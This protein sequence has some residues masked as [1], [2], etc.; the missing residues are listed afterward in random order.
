MADSKQNGETPKNKATAIT[1][2]QDA[3]SPLCSNGCPCLPKDWKLSPCALIWLV[4][5]AITMVMFLA[6]FIAPNWRDDDDVIIGLRKICAFDNCYNFVGDSRILK[7]G[8]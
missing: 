6:G 1:E 2:K 7:D 3:S 4:V 5:Y 8:K